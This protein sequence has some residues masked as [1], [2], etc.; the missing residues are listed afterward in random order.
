MVSF[1]FDSHTWRR[2]ARSTTTI[3]RGPVA[4]G[5][6]GGKEEIALRTEFGRLCPSHRQG[7]EG[8]AAV[9]TVEIGP[10]AVGRPRGQQGGAVGAMFGSGGRGE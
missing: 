2:Q 3:R 6:Q 4:I 5:E 1:L 10:D 7:R 9:I 8:M